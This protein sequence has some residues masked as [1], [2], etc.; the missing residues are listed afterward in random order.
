MNKHI[1]ISLGALALATVALAS[2]FVYYPLQLTA[3]P[4]APGVVFQLGSNAGHP[5]VGQ[6]TITVTLGASSTSAS[7]E[8]H[9]TYQRTYYKDVLRIY[10][11]DNDAMRIWLRVDNAYDTLPTGS[12]VRIIFREGA[13]IIYSY[14]IGGTAQVQVGTI[15][16]GA[17]WEIDF[18]VQIPEGHSIQN[19]QFVAHMRLIYTPSSETPPQ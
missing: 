14:Q 17:T 13:N 5:D 2:V 9:P 18:E 11:G 12:T 6:N 10:N 16:A 1:A 7:V 3:V 19:S 8:I 15:N 4:Q